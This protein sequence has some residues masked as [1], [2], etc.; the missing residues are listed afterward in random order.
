MRGNTPLHRLSL[1]RLKRGLGL[2]SLLGLGA[3][4][5]HGQ[6][7][8]NSD[9]RGTSAEGWV[10][11]GSSVSVAPYLTAAQGIDA[12]GDGWLRLTENSQNQS[13]YALLDTSIFSVNA[14]IQIEME[15]AFWNGSGA[16]G[17][18]FFL[19]DG[20]MNETTFSPGAYGGS[21]G[22]AQKDAAAGGGTAIPGMPGGYLGFGLD[23]FGNYSN[24]TEGRVGGPSSRPNAVAVRGPESSGYAY[25]AGATLNSYGQMDFPSSTTR[26]NQTGADYRSFRVTLDA[27][28]QLL[29]EMKFGAN[30]AYRNVFTADLS[31][32]DRPEYFKLGFTG[33]TGDSTEIHEIRNLKVTTT[34]WQPGAIEWDNGAG[35]TAWS[36]GNNWV[37]NVVPK[38]NADILFGNKPPTGPQTVVLNSAYQANSITFDSGHNYTLQGSGSLTMGNTGTAGLPSINVNDY[39]GEIGR[40][41]INI[42]ITL[43]ERTTVNNYSLSVLCINGIL[44]TNGNDIVV[45]GPGV[46]NFNA[47]IRGNGNLIKNGSGITTLN[48][49]NYDG[50]SSS[51]WNGNI[52]VNGGLL[53]VTTNGALGY[54]NGSTTVNSGGV[55]AFRD[56]TGG[57]LN[58]TRA[59]SV[60]I[61][62]RGVVRGSEGQTGAI[63]NDGGNNTFAGVITLAANAAVGSRDGNLRL[64]G[65]IVQ[66]GNNR[67]LTKLGNG[68]VTL[69]GSNS[70][71]GATIIENGALR[72]TASGA[73][74]SSDLQ[75]NGGVLE[76][77]YNATFSRGL[78]TGVNQV[79]WVGDGGFSA[80]GGNRTVQIGGN[81]NNLTWGSTANFV[82]NGSALLLSSNFSDSTI[83]F[84]NAISL[85]GAQ[86]EVRVADGAAAV[87]AILSGRLQGGNDGSGTG[88]LIKT[89]EGTLSLTVANNDYSGATEIRA[90][91]LRGTTGSNSNVQLQGGVRELNADY[92]GSLGT[93]GGAIRWMAGGGG[94]A[95]DT[96]A[97]TFNVGNEGETLTWGGK[98]DNSLHFVRNGDQLILGS[99]S[100]GGTLTFANA[101]DLNGGTE[102]IKVINSEASASLT[103]AIISGVISN[104]SLNVVGTGDL[105]L[106][107]A[108]GLEGSVNIAGA[109][110]QLSGA[111]T[112]GS[113]EGSFTIQKGGSLTL[114]NATGNTDRLANGAAINLQGG[115]LSLVGGNTAATQT[116][117]DIKLVSGG[118]TINVK[119][120]STST[121]AVLTGSKLAI[122]PTAT[123][124]VNFTNSG[125]GTLG[126]SGN[127]PLILFTTTPTLTNGLL[128]YA[129]VNGTSF[130][131]YNATTGIGALTTTAN[132]SQ[133]TW[134]S[135]VHTNLT[136]TQTM[137]GNR[138]LGSLILGA[139]GNVGQSGGSRTLTIESGGLLSTGSSAS[140]ISVGTL[141][142]GTNAP[143]L[144]AHVYGTGGLT[145]SSSITNNGG[146]TGLVKSGN[147]TLTL[148]GTAA[149]TYTGTTTVNDGMLVLAKS[150][151]VNAIAGNVKVGDGN[152]VDVLQL[153][154]NEQIANSANVSLVGGHLAST[155]EAVIKFN[156][157]SAGVTETF[158]TLSVEGRGVIDFGGG[159]VCE[160][161]YLFLD[162]LSIAA[163]STLYIRNWIDYTDFLL[164][165]ASE[166]PNL[167]A[168][169][170]QIKFE[171]YGDTASWEY[172]DNNYVRITPVP[173]PST[174]GAM[175][176]GAGLA[177]FGYRRWRTKRRS[178][179]S[180]PV[181]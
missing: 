40:H 143:N 111:G 124:T 97:R 129:T 6:T 45:N 104:G 172:Y 138:S 98:S 62:G 103:E 165:K 85:N 176:M 169:L 26:P 57:G 42:P 127:H 92:T 2:F 37:G 96:A 161:N 15:Y 24:P 41:K 117:G 137:N 72:Y 7:V 173:E 90:G 149:N 77:G 128:A 84:A 140:T 52:T 179:S 16:D 164:V 131:T 152:G 67:S 8:F 50:N 170:G 115:T 54:T 91:A 163:D 151:G 147:G 17:I 53:V 63:Y 19:V 130:A 87:D 81:S 38:P 60:T 25:I 58:Y 139:N 10:F 20:S 109:N 135:N 178:E 107:G 174:Y 119:P 141:R 46:V 55:L 142:A 51:R 61:S 177:V 65:N 113:V 22:Y 89:G 123:A 108:S 99:R 32:Y 73:L 56:T 122:D 35:T 154:A 64:T 180:L 145:I 9:F 76:I 106:T 28:N 27:N 23:N 44:S 101:I 116:V 168:I 69:S 162:S 144:Y 158:S 86:R 66:S 82:G 146:A 167:P 83:T 71:S 148:S 30:S 5:L 155:G 171:G 102:T 125:V 175:L 121:S 21:L 74:A 88:G 36:T 33:A 159:E 13:T 31:I 136:G 48:S 43:A 49:D 3:I 114:N 132:T 59:E 79:R 80:H 133:G 150:S 1:K 153:N 93:G 134:N 70:Y 157:G 11:G 14:Q 95:A 47:D 110:V 68:V 112:L 12:N 100:A 156:G 18:T 94:L 118:N 166:V 160:P 29:V 75:L 105:N 126:A 4:S 78:G 120:G 181:A 39:N 34:P